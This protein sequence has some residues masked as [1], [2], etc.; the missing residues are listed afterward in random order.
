MTLGVQRNSFVQRLPN[1]THHF[2][3]T[4]DFDFV[5]MLSGNKQAVAFFVQP[6]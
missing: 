2:P 1:K 3:G 6:T 4:G 5:G